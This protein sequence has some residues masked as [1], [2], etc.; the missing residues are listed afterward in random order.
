ME[1]REVDRPCKFENSGSG[2]R[3][4][5]RRQAVFLL[6]PEWNA[7]PLQGYPSPAPS[8]AL[9]SPVLV[10]YDAASVTNIWSVSRDFNN[11]LSV[12][13]GTLGWR[14]TLRVK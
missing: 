12:S 10:V 11:L 2:F 3:G 4:M 8:P 13:I 14:E 9:N 1:L 6:L 5:R 7:S